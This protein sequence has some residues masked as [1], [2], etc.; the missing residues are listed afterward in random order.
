MKFPIIETHQVVNNNFY[1]VYF[2]IFV[3]CSDNEGGGVFSNVGGTVVIASCSFHG[4]IASGSSGRGSAA[5]IKNANAIFQGCCVDYC[6]SQYGGDIQTMCDQDVSIRFINMQTFS[7]K[8]QYHPTFLRGKNVHAKFSNSSNNE[9]NS[10]EKFYG[11][12]L[13]F[14]KI[15]ILVA[16]FINGYQCNNAKSIFSFEMCDQNDYSIS[17]VNAI[18][19]QFTSI[20]SF[21]D[22]NKINLLFEY[23]FFISSNDFIIIE[24][25][26][27]ANNK[28]KFFQCSLS[29]GSNNSDDS[30]NF[31][32]CDYLQTIPNIIVFDRCYQ[33]TIIK[34]CEDRTKTFFNYTVSY[35][36]IITIC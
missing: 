5:Y 22:S 32:E 14:S 28:I 7:G 2:T 17:Y 19:N 21:A 9:V 23:S 11:S 31:E 34:T 4:C 10:N 27:A 1:H 20:I 16:Q 24:T 15:E 25:N 36:F 30:V 33:R 26:Q 13:C 12:I 29:I 18:E 3:N 35:L 6:K 8:M